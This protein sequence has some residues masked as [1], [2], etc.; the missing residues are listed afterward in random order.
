MNI[1]FLLTKYYTGRQWT[2]LEED[3]NQLTFHDDGPIPTLKEL[4]DLNVIYQEELKKTEYQRLREK[5]LKKEGLTK[6]ELIVALWERVMENRPEYSDELQKK[7][8]EV[9]AKI[10]KTVEGQD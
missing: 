3:Y 10:P 7:R 6:D 5:E 1:S 2:L 9:K 4:E 8:I